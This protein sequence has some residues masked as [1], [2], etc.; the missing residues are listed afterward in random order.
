MMVIFFLP[1]YL[2][3]RYGSPTNYD[4]YLFSTYLPTRYGSLSH[5]DGYLFST[6]LPD[7]VP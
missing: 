7:M 3:T 6:Y 4:G 5:H 1:T 2:P